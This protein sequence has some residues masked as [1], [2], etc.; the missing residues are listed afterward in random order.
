MCFHKNTQ[1]SSIDWFILSLCVL[2][3]DDLNG[4]YYIISVLGTGGT[5]MPIGFRNENKTNERKREICEQI[6]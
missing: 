4:N 1:F 3:N 5:E 2:F 6:M